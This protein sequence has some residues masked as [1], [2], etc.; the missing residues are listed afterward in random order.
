MNRK[1]G[2]PKDNLG[3]MRC[4]QRDRAGPGCCLQVLAVETGRNE[5]Q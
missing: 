4:A 1:P 3:R 5:A 2:G